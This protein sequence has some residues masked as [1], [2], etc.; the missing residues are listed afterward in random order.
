MTD[1]PLRTIAE[2]LGRLT[3]LAEVA[4]K[5]NEAIEESVAGFRAEVKED[6]EK[7]NGRISSLEKWRYGISGGA[8]LLGLMSPLFVLGIRENIAKLLGI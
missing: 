3:V 5:R 7:R 1:D 4:E 6:N 2:S 8:V